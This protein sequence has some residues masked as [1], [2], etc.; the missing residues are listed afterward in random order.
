MN[1]GDAYASYYSIQNLNNMCYSILIIFN[2]MYYLH[3]LVFGLEFR[4]FFRV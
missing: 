2:I 1:S 4:V 3:I